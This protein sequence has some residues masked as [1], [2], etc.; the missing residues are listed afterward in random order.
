MEMKKLL[1]FVERVSEQL[2]KGNP[3]STQTE[4]VFAR[5]VKLT[6]EVGELADEVLASQ[7]DQ[8]KEKLE[9]KNEESLGNEVADVLITT[10]VLAAS[11]N[12]DVPKALVKKIAKI[13]ARLPESIL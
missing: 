11:L 3:G 5:M 9:G 13:E 2:A 1:E 12:V 7:G 6:E 10:L 8:R 4:R